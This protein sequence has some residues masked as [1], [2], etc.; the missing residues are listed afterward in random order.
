MNIL[1]RFSTDTVSWAFG[2]R[3][4]WFYG[5]VED[6]HKNSNIQ[7]ELLELIE[8]SEKLRFCGYTSIQRKFLDT[9]DITKLLALKSEI[10]FANEFIDLGFSIE[11]IADNC[12][13]WPKKSP[14][15]SV[16]TTDKNFLI[17]VTRIGGD[18]T[19]SEILRELRELV[20][21]VHFLDV[22]I[23]FSQELSIPVAF[24]PERTERDQIKQDFIDH[25]S[26]IISSIQAESLPQTID[27]SGCHIELRQ[28]FNNL[29]QG[30]CDGIAD[31]VFVPREKLN[32]QI[33]GV[34]TKKAKKR[35]DW[36]QNQR[37]QPY[38]IALDLHQ[39]CQGDL[40]LTSL[41]FGSQTQYAESYGVPEYTEPEIVSQAKENGWLNFLTTVGYEPQ[42]NCRITQPGIL[43]TDN[44]IFKNVTGII[45]RIWGQLLFI[46]N[47]FAEEAINC[48]ESLDILPWPLHLQGGLTF[49]L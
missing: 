34:L 25:F 5:L 33:H 23:K 14:D 15:L 1:E 35:E 47:P 24:G 10:L 13:N 48:L 8:L 19:I 17:E 21:P 38:F 42:S 46:P 4:Q 36:D 45:V 28:N 22:W 16:H 20:K 11:M 9:K 26:K 39:E 32:S 43:I 30:F 29:E 44:D 7:H 31:A 18:D 3:H 6:L 49:E 2:D 37:S 12:S 27:I 41:L 40:E